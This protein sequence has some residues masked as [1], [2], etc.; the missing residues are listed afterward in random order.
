VGRPALSAYPIHHVGALRGGPQAG[1]AVARPRSCLVFGLIG[2]RLHAG[3][4]R[5]WLTDRSTHVLAVGDGFQMRRP[6][7]SGSSAQVV[8]H[9]VHG[10]L[11][12]FPPVGHPVRLMKIAVHVETAVTVCARLFPQPTGVRF[13]YGLP[14][15]Y[16]VSCIFI[17]VDLPTIGRA[18]GR[19]SGCGAYLLV[20]GSQIIH[21]REVIILGSYISRPKICERPGQVYRA[22]NLAPPRLNFPESVF[23]GQSGSIPH[24]GT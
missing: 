4:A 1:G 7:T 2:A 21:L 22:V 3:N 17:H 6:H 19:Y 13:V 10:N 20:R 9:K 18:P 11:A 16:A 14:K 24:D 23:P 5:A 8:N 12:V 15:P